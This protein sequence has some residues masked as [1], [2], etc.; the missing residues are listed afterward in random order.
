MK[1]TGA[2]TFYGKLT[3]SIA[4]VTRKTRE[5]G[6]RANYFLILGGADP[7]NP[8]EALQGYAAILTTAG[9]PPEW[10]DGLLTVSGVSGLDALE[11]DAIIE[12][13]PGTEHFKV[14]YRPT[15]TSNVLFV[16]SACNNQCI[17]CSQPPLKES[18]APLEDLL[19]IIDLIPGHPESLGISGGE[20]TLLKEGLCALLS[21][22]RDRLPQTAVHVLTNGRLYAYEDYVRRLKAIGHPR[23]T[24]A[25]PLYADT[26][27]LHDA[28]VGVP[29]AF[30]QAV[31]GIYH[32][33]QYG[34]AVEIRIVLQRPTVARLSQ[35]AEFIYRNFPFAVHIAFMGLEN[36]GAAIRNWD[37]LWIDP[38]DYTPILERSAR[39]LFVRQMA[40]SIYNHQLCTLPRSLWGLTRQSISDYKTT[41]LAECQSCDVQKLCGG[42]FVSSKQ[43]HSRMLHPIRLHCS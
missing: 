3:T 11:E 10:P 6:E 41:Y 34:L 2:G 30:D 32:L 40:V 27:D 7:Q 12:L 39:A 4:R 8:S 14:L 42:L 28:I 21:H 13:N 9:R 24:S 1:L 22:L 38:A 23:F 35:L 20:P 37:K 26:A 43:R 5:P 17:M 31:R 29:G 19:R 18:D 15:S 25:I 36:M 16:T 33:A